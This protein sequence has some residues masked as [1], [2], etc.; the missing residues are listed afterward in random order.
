MRSV[1]RQYARH[2]RFVADVNRF[3]THNE[4]TLEKVMDFSVNYM[5]LRMV[6]PP[7]VTDDQVAYAVRKCS[8]ED[9]DIPELYRNLI[10]ELTGQEIIFRIKRIKYVKNSKDSISV[11]VSPL[12]KNLGEYMQM[13]TLTLKRK[14]VTVKLNTN[15]LLYDYDQ[16][17]GLHKGKDPQTS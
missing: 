13:N 7:E 4:D 10:E 1:E 12:M 9:Y 3:I 15:C 8:G 16:Q 14:G 5:A 11:V 17:Q 2:R 6:H